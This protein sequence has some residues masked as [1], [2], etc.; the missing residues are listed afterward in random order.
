MKQANIIKLFD[1]TRQT[2]TNWK[3]QDKKIV[4]LLQYFNDEDIEYLML[5]NKIPK[6][7]HINIIYINLL[8]KYNDY[9]SKVIND[10]DKTYYE[11]ISVD[12]D[13][14]YKEIF[15]STPILFIFEL[16]SHGWENNAIDGIMKEIA[17]YIKNENYATELHNLMQ[18]NNDIQT[19]LDIFYEEKSFYLYYKYFPY[20]KGLFRD[21]VSEN[22]KKYFDFYIALKKLNR[23][24]ISKDEKIIKLQSLIGEHFNIDSTIY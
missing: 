7:E 19:L 20:S 6:L 15:I 4:T 3:N 11:Q 10:T 2:W 9:I 24:T 13:R 16:I 17:Q 12:F 23:D 18:I 14:A 8:G 5:E 21:G 22:H 1:I